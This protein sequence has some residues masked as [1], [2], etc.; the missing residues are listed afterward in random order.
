MDF[1]HCD[2]EANLFCKLKPDTSNLNPG[3]LDA[4]VVPLCT[5]YIFFCSGKFRYDYLKCLFSSKTSVV[6]G[7][8]E[9]PKI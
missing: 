9:V 2:V 8:V 5:V 4:H 1:I 3:I 6:V 7:L